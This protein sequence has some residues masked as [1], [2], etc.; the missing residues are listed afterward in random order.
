MYSPRPQPAAC[1]SC[2]GEID[3]A[4]D[5]NAFAYDGW[6][7]LHLA[8][9]FGHLDA[10]R[11]L[12]DAGADI[13]AFSRN[14]LTNTPLHAA[15]A[16][17]HGDVALLLVEHGADGLVLDAG[18]VYGLRRSRRRIGLGRGRAQSTRLDVASESEGRS[19][20]RMINRPSAA[21]SR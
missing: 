14:G 11:A 21:G 17:R 1:L 16:G 4:D 13:D 5:L 20:P 8:A 6:T 7:P 3:K 15:T 2:A 9:F 10:A 19:A 12:I 18:R